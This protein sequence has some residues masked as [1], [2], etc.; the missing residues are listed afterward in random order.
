MVAT[1]SLLAGLL[2]PAARGQ[3]PRAAST[4]HGFNTGIVVGGDWL[5]ANALPLDRDA[6]QSASFDVSLRR[7]AW[8]VGAGFMRIARDLSTVQGGYISGGPMFHW[9]DVLFMPSVGALVGQASA[10]ADTTGYD[11]VS[12]GVAG[13]QPRYSYSDGATFGGSVGLAIEVPVFRMIGVRAGASEWF[14]SGTPLEN[15]R[16]RTVVSVGL[17][18]RAWR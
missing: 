8:F 1:A 12:G 13:H 14:F 16:A 15:D 3:Q 10:S 9:K 18:V 11:Y 17:S 6:M 7:N 4:S 5:Q 2:A